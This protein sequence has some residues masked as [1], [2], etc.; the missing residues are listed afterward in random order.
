MPSPGVPATRG[1]SRS[2]RRGQ[3]VAAVQQAELELATEVLNSFS[4]IYKNASEIVGALVRSPIRFPGRHL[5]KRARRT[6]G[7]WPAQ[8]YSP[9]AFRRLVAELGIVGRV[10]QASDHARIITADFEY[11]NRGRLELQSDDDCVFHPMFFHR[12]HVKQDDQW[13]VYPFPDHPGS[14][15]NWHFDDD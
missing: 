5:D 7:E 15:A 11:F 4:R 1:R 12:L 13:T 10:R 6:A 8:M 3:I 2:S 9:L 14:G